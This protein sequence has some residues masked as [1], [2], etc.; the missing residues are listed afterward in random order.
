MVLAPQVT[1]ITTELLMFLLLD[2]CRV[3]LCLVLTG[4]WS[5]E[6]KRSSARLWDDCQSKDCKNDLVQYSFFVPAGKEESNQAAADQ[7]CATPQEA[8][9]Q[10]KSKATE[11]R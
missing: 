1:V 7:E 2:F 10:R 11:N 5:Q 6:L 3:V 8:M 4:W 9:Q